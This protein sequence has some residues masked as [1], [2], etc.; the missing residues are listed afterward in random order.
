M[1]VKDNSYHLFGKEQYLISKMSPYHLAVIFNNLKGLR[2]MTNR[3]N[4]H[5]RLC[6]NGPEINYGGLQVKDQNI[7]HK[8]SWPLFVAINNMNLKM[9]MYLWQDLGNIY[10]TSVG[11]GYGN[12]NSVL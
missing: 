3:L 6:M 8:E 9:L 2:Y 11:T 12:V 5:M 7:I 10:N 1:N 4:K